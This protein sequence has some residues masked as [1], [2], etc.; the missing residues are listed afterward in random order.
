MGVL[1][2]VATLLGGVAAVWYFW[3][4]WGERK[5]TSP[6]KSGPRKQTSQPTH[7]GVAVVLH[8]ELRAFGILMGEDAGVARQAVARGREILRATIAEF[9]GRLSQGPADAILA[10]FDDAARSLACAV[11]ARGALARA[12]ATLP[13]AERVHYRF[14]IDLGANA[15]SGGSAPAATIERAAAI[16]LRAPTDAVRLTEAVRAR[17]PEEGGPGLSA[18]EPGVFALLDAD[19]PVAPRPGP[20]QLEAMALPLP[21]RP[22]ILLLPFSCTGQDPDGAALAD[23]LRLDIQNA[24]VKMSGVF[25]IAAG[26]ANALRG[27]EAREAALRVGVR[28]VLE[29]NVQRQGETVRV[30]VR[31]VDA[32]AGAVTWSERY[33]RTLDDSFALQ[34][35]IAGR[36]VTALDVKLASGEEARIWRKCLTASKAREVFYRG[37]QSFFQ[38]NPDAMAAARASFERVA[39]LVPESSMGPSWIAMCLWFEV[40]RGWASDPQRARAAAGEWAERAVDKTD[41]D[42]QAHTVLGNVRLLQRRFDEALA[43]ARQAAVIR[44]NCTNANSFLANVLVHCGEPEGAL[45]HVKRAI[46]YSP[47][48]PPWFL[49]ILATAY[50][51]SGQ[52]DFAV[53]AAHEGLRILPQSINC[54]LILASALAR[55]GWTADA[56][57][58]ARDL[59]GLEPTFSLARHAANAPYR[60][61]AVLERI[62]GE[63]RSAGLPN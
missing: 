12:N 38:M 35:E 44:P 23:G 48:Y 6:A 57:R 61:A 13:P 41:A 51:E 33:D 46:R 31:L 9:G 55:G 63:L 36:V 49:E 59:V 39:E 29:G 16:V 27:V 1:L 15:E 34:D 60:D 7:G 14:G 40:A 62:V 2:A 50:R 53:A 56:Q 24:L 42:G 45:A 20:P 8:S 17:L 21:D 11:A 4:K 10:V 37:M 47:V 52:V 30:N 58:V 5:A 26:T 19:G 22:S 32:V 18:V 3:D 28:H 25:L 54:R 43:I